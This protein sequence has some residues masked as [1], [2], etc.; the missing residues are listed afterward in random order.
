MSTFELI[1]ERLG[2]SDRSGAWRAWHTAMERRESTAVAALREQETE[3][4]NDLWR[5]MWPQAEEGDAS[6][7]RVCVSVVAQMTRLHGLYAPQAVI[8]YH[9]QAETAQREQQ[10]ERE[11]TLAERLE[12]DPELIPL[13]IHAMEMMQETAIRKVGCQSLLSRTEARQRPASNAPL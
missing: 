2:Y 5:V 8:A 11:E 6:S 10:E 12:S 1:A 7:A 9:H 3:R 13:A 4:L